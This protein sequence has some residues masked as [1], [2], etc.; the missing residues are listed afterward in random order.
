MFVA[1]A[2]DAAAVQVCDVA[3][4]L[5][6]YI[7]ESMQ[8]HGAI[9]IYRTQRAI[10]FIGM[11][12]S[13]REFTIQLF[14]EKYDNIQDVLREFKYGPHP[15]AW[16]GTRLW[17]TAGGK[18][19]LEH[20]AWV[21]STDYPL[22]VNRWFEHY[23]AVVPS[24]PK[25]DTSSKGINDTLYHH[26]KFGCNKI[27]KNI[28]SNCVKVGALW[29]IFE[30][31]CLADARY[32]IEYEVF[33][34]YRF[35]DRTVTRSVQND[36][37]I[38]NALILSGNPLAKNKTLIA[39]SSIDEVDKVSYIE[40]II[41]VGRMKEIITECALKDIYRS[42]SRIIDV[43]RLTALLGPEIALKLLGEIVENPQQYCA[44]SEQH[45][46]ISRCEDLNRL[47]HIPFPE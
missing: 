29:F 14:T 47:A 17:M 2:G 35:L 33:Y 18:F 34:L 41:K 39:M 26:Y 1:K 5:K 23:D 38:Q 21:V 20:G 43:G 30:E 32:S 42:E 7:T 25:L 45:L 22:F 46:C 13:K 28:N 3:E 40:P 19:S 4:E 31:E 12:D 10:T 15:V 16:D 37:I 44:S 11:A 9:D 36:Y 24:I 8:F 27:H 6:R